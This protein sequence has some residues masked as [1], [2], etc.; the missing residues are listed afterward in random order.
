MYKKMFDTDEEQRA[1][2]MGFL[3]ASVAEVAAEIL[4]EADVSLALQAI[5]TI[6]PEKLVVDLLMRTHKKYYV[7]ERSADRNSLAWVVSTLSSLHK[8]MV[9]LEGRLREKFGENR[10]IN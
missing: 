6:E 2:L 3:G 7:M 4:G 9:E 10:G 5:E 1:F 8:T